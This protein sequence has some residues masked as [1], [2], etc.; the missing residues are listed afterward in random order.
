[1]G[2]FSLAIKTISVKA[3][4]VSR[5]VQRKL[6]RMSTLDDGE[7]SIPAYLI[8]QFGKNFQ[9]G[10]NDSIPGSELLSLAME[11][12]LLLQH[13]VGGVL[14]VL[15]CENKK[16]LLDFYCAQNHF[17]EFGARKTKFTEKDL[18]QLLKTI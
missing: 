17:V 14:C 3:Q 16:Q 1:M 12:I 18:L 10:L 8:A 7:Y 13:G 4:N 5:T 15:E 9:L 11:Q 2:Y 6:S